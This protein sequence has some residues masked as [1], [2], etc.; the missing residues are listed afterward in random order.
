MKRN[1]AVP[2]RQLRV[3]ASTLTLQDEGRGGKKRVGAEPSLLIRK[4]E[5]LRGL[6][7]NKSVAEEPTAKLSQLGISIPIPPK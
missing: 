7:A 4:D 3:R 5:I 1:S 2:E 6:R